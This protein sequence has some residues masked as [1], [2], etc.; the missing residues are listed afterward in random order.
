MFFGVVA[1]ATEGGHVYLMDMRMDDERGEFDE[2]NP[3]HMK[4]LQPGKPLTPEERVR[5]REQGGH[6]CI[7][8]GGED[9]WILH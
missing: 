7:E 1:V 9:S 6:L 8:L 4:V 3:S 5:T 2:W